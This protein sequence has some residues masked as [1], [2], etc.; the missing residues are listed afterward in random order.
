MEL[1]QKWLFEPAP[2]FATKNTPFVLIESPY[3]EYLQLPYLYGTWI[4]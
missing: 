4:C 1:F 3:P 2:T